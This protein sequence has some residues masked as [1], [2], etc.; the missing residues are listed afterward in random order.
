M[1]GGEEEEGGGGKEVCFA[2]PF[3][4]R[5]FLMDS[6]RMRI[7]SGGGS[8]ALFFALLACHCRNKRQIREMRMHLEGLQL[9]AAPR[10]AA[11]IGKSKPALTLANSSFGQQR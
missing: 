7:K 5:L 10:C 11:K 6:A 1:W 8:Q 4:G 9:L 3:L 2:L